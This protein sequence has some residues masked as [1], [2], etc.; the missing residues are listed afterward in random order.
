MKM[1][2]KKAKRFLKKN[3]LNLTPTK[4][5]T[6]SDEKKA[7]LLKMKAEAE[8]VLNGVGSA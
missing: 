5:E 6:Y 1:S 3:E 8:E 7:K 2:V 4:L